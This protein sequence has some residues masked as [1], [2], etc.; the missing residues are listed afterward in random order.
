MTPASFHPEA[1]AEFTNELE[2]YSG[3]REGVAPR[4]REC[5]ELA[6]ARAIAQP[7]GGAPSLRGTRSL[8]VKGF[9]LS[10]IYRVMDGRIEV[11]ALAPHRRRPGYWLSRLR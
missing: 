4:F 8:C 2:F 6:V 11:I 5:V 3:T 9:P 10:V 7:A 1:W